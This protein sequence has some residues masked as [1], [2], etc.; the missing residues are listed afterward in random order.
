MSKDSIS[1]KL[2]ELFEL[3]KSGALTKEEFE[4]LKQ[5]LL[6]ENDQGTKENENIKQKERVKKP[7]KPFPVRKVISISLK[8]IGVLLFLIA[9]FLIV[10][11]I[12]VVK[13]YN[14]GM[15]TDSVNPMLPYYFSAFLLLSA[16]TTYIGIKL[17][18]G[19][20]A[21]KAD[22]VVS[23]ILMVIGVIFIIGN[24]GVIIDSFSVDNQVV[25]DNLNTGAARATPSGSLPIS[26]FILL[27]IS[28]GLIFIGFKLFKRKF[29]ELKAVKN[30]DLSADLKKRPNRRTTIIATTAVSLCAIL[31]LLLFM[32]N[33]DKLT[34]SGSN[35]PNESLKSFFDLYEKGD[36]QLT[37]YIESD[38]G[39][40]VN[41][42]DE[43]NPQGHPELISFP[44]VIDLI[45][46]TESIFNTSPKNE[47]NGYSGCKDGFYY[48]EIEAS[49]LP[50]YFGKNGL[51]GELASFK[52][53]EVQLVQKES[54]IG[55]FCFVMVDNNWYLFY[56]G[57]Y[58]L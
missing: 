39:L 47:Y 26:S 5:Q 31:A 33:R 21:I 23:I 24:I 27:L 38:I 41:L 28:G 44:K 8:V 37:D 7:R 50:S 42:M 53:L 45:I 34:S 9:V 16:I 11:Y 19:R 14:T 13:N 15:T 43:Y 57:F 40:Y 49:D 10:G 18:K 48:K 20:K 17:S 46:P 30:Q 35:E 6:L 52:I 25:L 29:K 1:T 58:D 4:N 2:T 3:H 55:E 54:L 32:T 56:Q 51:M 22:I 36:N 12:I